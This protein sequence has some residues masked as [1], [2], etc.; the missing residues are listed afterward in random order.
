M[1]NYLTLEFVSTQQ[2]LENRDFKE[3]LKTYALVFNHCFQC[4][5]NKFGFANNIQHLEPIGQEDA[6]VI[7]SHCIKCTNCSLEI[8]YKFKDDYL[9]DTKQSLC[10]TECEIRF[11]LTDVIINDQKTKIKVGI[12]YDKNKT[13]LWHNWPDKGDNPFW[14]KMQVLLPPT[15][16]SSR[17]SNMMPLL[18]SESET[19]FGGNF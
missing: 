1:Q 3:F 8:N 4:G 10:F 16:S 7:I 2:L 19:T 11:S 14:I 6:P 13:H 17:L 18:G 15:I 5:E 12:F 9:E